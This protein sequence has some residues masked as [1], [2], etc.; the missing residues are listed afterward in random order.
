[1]EKTIKELQKIAKNNGF[2][3]CPNQIWNQVTN[4]IDY[5]DQEIKRI[6]KERENWRNKYFKLKK[7]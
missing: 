2:Y 3:L 7:K 4:L 5:K 6:K 1:M